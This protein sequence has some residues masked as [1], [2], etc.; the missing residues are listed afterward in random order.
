MKK[1]VYIALILCIISSCGPKQEKVERIIEDGVEVVIN[2]LE[3]YQIKG[4]PI[5][6]HLEEKFSIDTEDNEIAEKGLVDMETFDVDEEGNLYIIRWTSNEN[7]VYKFDGQG[8]F[9]SSF[10]R[11]GQGPGEI[12]WGGTVM[13]INDNE[14][15]VKDPG[16]TRFSIYDRNGRFLRDVQM[17][18]HYSLMRLNAD[19][20]YLAFRQDQDYES[21][22]FDNHIGFCSPDFSDFEIFYSFQS[23][24]AMRAKRIEVS[25][26]RWVWE[27][28]PDHLYIGKL[29]LGYE[30][31][32]YDLTGTVVRKIRKAYEPVVMSE[33]FKKAYMERIPKDYPLRDKFYFPDH[34]PAF[35]YMFAD[36]QDR[37]YV[38]T[39]ELGENPGEYIYDI[40]NSEGVFIANTKLANGGDRMP[41]D[42][43]VAQ[44]HV[45]FIREKE[46]GYKELMVYK[47]RWE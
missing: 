38:M 43:K 41:F 34:W 42:A 4:E 45:Y 28:A 21:E 24:N 23:S 35:Q 33:D 7:Y 15:I 37:L 8:E 16:K 18:K 47:M 31:W 5:N 44:N 27:P 1:L 19:G 6:L 9:M 30:I 22:F 46:S 10:V 25:G 11:R 17:K 13:L 36:E 12:E 29:D 3:P 26:N 32:V 14:L 2:H 39:Y 20:R 40:F